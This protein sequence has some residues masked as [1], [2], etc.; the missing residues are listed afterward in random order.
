MLTTSVAPKMG[1]SVV[2]AILC[3]F[4]G[5]DP[6]LVL[7]S[8]K[9]GLRSKFIR[10]KA[11]VFQCTNP[12]CKRTFS[13]KVDC[14]LHIRHGCANL[15]RYKCGGCDYRSNLSGDIKKHILGV[16]KDTDIE[17]VTLWDPHNETRIYKCPTFGCPARYKTKAKLAS[18]MRHVCGKEPRFKCFYCDHKGY[19]K[20][21]VKIHCLSKHPDLEFMFVELE[22]N[23]MMASRRKSP[24]ITSTTILTGPNKKSLIRVRD[25]RWACTNPKCD[26]TFKR[27][28]DRNKHSRYHCDKPRRF[29]CG[30][31]NYKSHFPKDIRNHCSSRHKEH[32]I[33]VVELYPKIDIRRYACPA[34]N[35][36]KKYKYAKSLS[37]HMKFECGR[38]ARFKYFDF[39]PSSP[40]PDQEPYQETDDPLAIL[41]PKRYK[42]GYCEA[43]FYTKSK[44]LRHLAQQ[45]S[46]KRTKIIDLIEECEKE[47]FFPC[48]NKGCKK[49][50]KREVYL[51]EHL[52]KECGKKPSYQCGF[53]EMQFFARK[54]VTGHF[55]RKHPGKEVT[56][57]QISSDVL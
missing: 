6:L 35:C 39:P 27:K 24:R 36:G 41:N 19:F 1:T 3:I 9:S 31:C 17:M 10:P 57:D 18:H 55:R 23:N 33:N 26:K 8:S 20:D 29:K 16:H 14:N 43:T 40:E 34:H 50:Y 12:N 49:I 7:R 54:R 30:Y 44:I 15:Q 56:F 51:K 4:T 2:T 21:R 53:C 45:H 37:N 11:Q 32:P 42:C 48:P 47:D 52:T 38:P 46:E 25:Q 22:D 28:A 13:S 5:G